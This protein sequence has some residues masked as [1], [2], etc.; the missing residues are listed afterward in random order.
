MTEE[1]K[2]MTQEDIEKRAAILD[3]DKKEIAIMK[4]DIILKDLADTSIIPRSFHAKIVISEQLSK[5]TIIPD[6]YRNK[7][8]DIFTAL[9]YGEMVGLRNPLAC[10]QSVYVVKGKPSMSADSMIGLCMVQPEF[11]GYEHKMSADGKEST[12][13]IKVKQPDGSIREAVGYHTF[14]MSQK[15]ETTGSTQWKSDPANMLKHRSDSKAA[16]AAFPSVLNGIYIPD[17]RREQNIIEEQDGK[18]NVINTS[19]TDIKNIFGK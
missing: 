6:V 14:E 10:L 17:E 11:M 13:I 7:P 2:Q 4:N 3:N 16:R 19:D 5:S 18:G 1:K 8:D 12:T 15:A 9:Q